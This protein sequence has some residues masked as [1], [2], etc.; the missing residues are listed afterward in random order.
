LERLASNSCSRRGEAFCPTGQY[1]SPQLIAVHGFEARKGKIPKKNDVF[2]LEQKV[3]L[4]HF[5][6]YAELPLPDR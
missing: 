2:Q 1:I 4:L 3:I 6:G 5:K